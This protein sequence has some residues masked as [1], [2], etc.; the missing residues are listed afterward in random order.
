L[1]EARGDGRGNQSAGAKATDRYTGD[2]ASPVGEP[3][4][5]YSNRND[6]SEAE[7]NAADDSIAEVEPPEV[8]GGETGEE[9]AE[10]V[11]NAASDGDDS[12]AGF[13]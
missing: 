13:I 1:N 8:I 10:S 3:F 5:Q 2:E 11:E 9:N 12:R 4:D 6:V 7:A